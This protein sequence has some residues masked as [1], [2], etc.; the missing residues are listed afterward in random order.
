MGG[1]DDWGHSREGYAAILMDS[2]MPRCDGP[3]ATKELRRLGYPGAIFA[4][5]GN[6][7][8][9]DVDYFL[10]CVHN[11]STEA[12]YRA[13]RPVRLSPSH[14]LPHFPRLLSPTTVSLGACVCV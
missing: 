2:V 1:S 10:R 9:T 14:S 12:L 4:L 7:V 5:T 8:D 13:P 3:T 6:A 11:A